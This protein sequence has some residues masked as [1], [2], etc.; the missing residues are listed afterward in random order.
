M[1][2]GANGKL[3]F[4]AIFVLNLLNRRILGSLGLKISFDT[5]LI[6][7]GIRLDFKFKKQPFRA[8]RGSCDISSFFV[9]KLSFRV[10]FVK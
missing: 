7:C 8:F 5:F 6:F 3:F 10:S 9:K 2:T 1:F 4:C